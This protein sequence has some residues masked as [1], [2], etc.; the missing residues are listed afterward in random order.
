MQIQ[1]DRTQLGIRV[2]YSLIGSVFVR[3]ARLIAE[4]IEY[5]M[6]LRT[7]ST[8]LIRLLKEASLVRRAVSTTT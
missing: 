6:R 1:I 5:L 3:G 7:L 4:K 8:T 2:A